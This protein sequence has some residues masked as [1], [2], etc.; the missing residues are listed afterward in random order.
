MAE[1]IWTDPALTDLDDIAEYIALEN[2][3]AA[4]AL[5]QK[6]FSTVERLEQHPQSGRT[7]S[8]LPGDR[9]REI[10]CGPCRVFYR[11]TGNKVLI[12]HVMRS[13]RELRNF[14][15]EDG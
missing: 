10:V 2:P 9:Y 13:E 8:E 5:V 15:I 7:P 6:V 11:H 14:L 1:L 3:P 12:L 4:R